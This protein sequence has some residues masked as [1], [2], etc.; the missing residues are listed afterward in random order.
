MVL[1]DLVYHVRLGERAD[2]PELPVLVRGHLAEDAAHD[3]AGA[4]L[5][6][7]AAELKRRERLS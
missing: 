2:V 6:K 3:L 1:Y 4:G 5:G 7:G